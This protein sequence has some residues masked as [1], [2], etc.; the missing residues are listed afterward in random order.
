M[1]SWDTSDFQ[2]SAFLVSKV[3]ASGYHEMVIYKSDYDDTERKLDIIYQHWSMLS[4]NTGDLYASSFWW[5]KWPVCIRKLESDIK[6]QRF[7]GYTGQLN[8]A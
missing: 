1:L 6:M 4:W 3:E 5:V 2:A 7:S 8:R